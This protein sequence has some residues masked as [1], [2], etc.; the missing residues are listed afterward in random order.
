MFFIIF[1]LC[2]FIFPLFNSSSKLEEVA[3]ALRVTEES[4][5]LNFEF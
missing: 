1:Y 2:S 3:L 5:I 4:E